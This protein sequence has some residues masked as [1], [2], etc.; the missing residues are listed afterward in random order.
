MARKRFE[1]WLNDQRQEDWLVYELIG[2]LKKPLK[3]QG[4]FTRAI[5]E[6]L[7]LWTSLRDGQIDVLLE[8]FPWVKEALAKSTTSQTTSGAAGNDLAKEIAAQ[9]ILQGGTAGYLMQSTSP[10][11]PKQI[12][13]K[14]LTAPNFDMPKF[15]DEDELKLVIKADTSNAANDN[16]ISMLKGMAAEQL[17]PKA[18]V[19]KAHKASASEI[20]DNFLGMG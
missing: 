16:F 6:G 14:Q 20:T 17:A 13:G 10:S 9:I 1:F 7:R 12:T 3:G 15:D 2:K 8:L 11:Q 18:V 4:Q 5:R 19:K